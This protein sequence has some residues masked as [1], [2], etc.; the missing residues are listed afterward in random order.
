MFT[1]AHRNTPLASVR[2]NW[3][4][5][6]WSGIRE[7]NPRLDLGK[8]AYYHYTNPAWTNAFIAW[9]R[10][11]GKATLFSARTKRAQTGA[12]KRKSSASS[13]Q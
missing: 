11:S 8:V 2:G 13:P 6:E 7:S 9:V 12:A 3:E 10:N 1:R 5:K 4:E